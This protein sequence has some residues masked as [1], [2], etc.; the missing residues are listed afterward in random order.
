MTYKPILHNN[1][2]CF[3]NEVVSAREGR[4]SKGMNTVWNKRSLCLD[5][6]DVAWIRDTYIWWR[7]P[8][9]ISIL[10]KQNWNTGQALF[11]CLVEFFH[12]S[13]ISLQF[14]K[15]CCSRLNANLIYLRNCYLLP[16]FVNTTGCRSHASK[17]MMKFY[18]ATTVFK[19]LCMENNAMSF[20][21]L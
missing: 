1:K 16:S 2:N 7:P 21:I 18:F 20:M 4:S 11:C 8:K 6:H 13:Y 9:I 10:K 17:T 14:K 3:E 19:C 15:G 12:L 5:I